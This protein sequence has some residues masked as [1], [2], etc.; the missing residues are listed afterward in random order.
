L[1]QVSREP[2]QSVVLALRPAKLNRHVLT[3]DVTRLIQTFAKADDSTGI[4]VGRPAT[5]ESDHRN[6]RLLSAHFERPHARRAGEY[7][8]ELA[9]SHSITSSARA[10]IDGG[11]W[12]NKPHALSLSETIVIDGPVAGEDDVG[13][14]LIVTRAASKILARIP[15]REREALL[16]KAE[17][18]AAAPFAVHPA[19]TPLRGQPDVIRLRQ[20]D[21]RGICRVDRSADTIVLETVAHRREAYR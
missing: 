4:S 11:I 14:K 15:R 19:A 9:P 6:R 5:E 1:D 21:W 18:F 8:N 13:I 3:V 17:A 20:S 16:D 2:R 12:D 10:R 7:R